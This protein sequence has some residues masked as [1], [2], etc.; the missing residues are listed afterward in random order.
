MDKKIA[1]FKRIPFISS[2]IAAAACVHKA[3][4]VHRDLH[5]ESIPDSILKA[6]R[7]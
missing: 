7:L 4:L 6:E 3:K 1:C 2:L 5:F